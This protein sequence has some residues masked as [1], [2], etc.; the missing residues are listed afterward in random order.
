L[1]EADAHR[2]ARL[3]SGLL[4]DDDQT[5]AAV[6]TTSSAR[7]RFG[8]PSSLGALRPVDTVSTLHVSHASC[9]G[10]NV[11]PTA[12]ELCVRNSI[13][14]KTLF[15]NMTLALLNPE[16]HVIAQSIGALALWGFTVSAFGAVSSGS[17]PCATVWPL[18]LRR[19]EQMRRRVHGLSLRRSGGSTGVQRQS[20]IPCVEATSPLAYC[21]TL[22][23]SNVV[24][25]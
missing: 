17:G 16:Q 10:G 12:A 1:R 8:S 22:G 4:R 5:A 13:S 14:L 2:L 6:E 23:Y 3:I 15:Q 11:P 19:S 7:I 20:R 24:N 25:H 18:D 9:S 21:N